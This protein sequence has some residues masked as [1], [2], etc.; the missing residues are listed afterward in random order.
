MS[1]FCHYCSNDMPEHGSWFTL[2][3]YRGVPEDTCNH[4]C[5]ER[6]GAWLWFADR[7]P[8]LIVR[9]NYSS[10]NMPGLGTNVLS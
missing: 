6:R 9:S 1:S 4:C 5:E 7:C 8:S 10:R 3:A 2:I